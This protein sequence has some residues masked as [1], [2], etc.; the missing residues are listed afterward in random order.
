[1]IWWEGLIPLS[2]NLQN[3]LEMLPMWQQT[4]LKNLL[5]KSKIADS[6]IKNTAIACLQVNLVS[7]NNFLKGK[8]KSRNSNL[9]FR[10]IGQGDQNKLR[11]PYN[12]KI[13]FYH[14]QVDDK[15]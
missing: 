7:L 1:M 5:N 14:L 10:N 15:K 11:G 4:L 12:L 13:L 9:L 3:D 2:Q 8:I 6:Q